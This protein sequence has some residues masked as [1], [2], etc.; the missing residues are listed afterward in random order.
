MQAESNQNRSPALVLVAVLAVAIVQLAWAYARLPEIMATHFGGTGRANGWMP[1]EAF[2]AFQLG[3]YAVILL[4][5]VGPA[6]VLGKI[7]AR[8]FSLPNRDYWLAPERSART[9]AHI[10]RQLW[11]MASATLLF[12]VGVTEL[13]IRVNLGAYAAL[14]TAPLLALLGA[15]LLYTLIWSLRFYRYFRRPPTG[16]SA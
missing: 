7:P 11:W 15:F 2:V 13:V 3:L 16:R 6:Q 8:W 10:R 1:R 14:P 9:A 5:F 12:T 4:S